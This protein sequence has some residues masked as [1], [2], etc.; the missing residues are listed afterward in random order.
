MQ[1]DPMNHEITAKCW[2]FEM[3][4]M[5]KS[6]RDFFSNRNQIVLRGI[7]NYTSIQ[8]KNFV[9]FIWKL[10][11][12]KVVL[13]FDKRGKSFIYYQSLGNKYECMTESLEQAFRETGYNSFNFHKENINLY[14]IQR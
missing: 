2:F 9:V 14:K 10:Q 7:Y 5:R 4:K 3:N 8:T 1:D 13:K 11:K 6:I 12:G